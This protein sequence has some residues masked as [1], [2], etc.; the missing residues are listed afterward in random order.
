MVKERIEAESA[1]HQRGTSQPPHIQS[2]RR[3]KGMWHA[4]SSSTE[5]LIGRRVIGPVFLPSEHDELPP[6]VAFMVSDVIHVSTLSLI[7]RSACIQDSRMRQRTRMC[8]RF[9]GTVWHTGLRNSGRH[10]TASLGPSHRRRVGPPKRAYWPSQVCTG[11]RTHMSY[12][13]RR[14]KHQSVGSQTSG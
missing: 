5:L 4:L 9:I 2:S 7:M 10:S 8:S 12:W 3:R 11:R 13:E 1:S 14:R 6:G